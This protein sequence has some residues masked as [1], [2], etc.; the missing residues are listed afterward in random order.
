MASGT[1]KQAFTAIEA[2][3]YWQ[4]FLDVGLL[5]SLAKLEKEDENTLLNILRYFD[6]I[7]VDLR[8]EESLSQA[9]KR[10]SKLKTIRKLL[11]YMPVLIQFDKS[12]STVQLKS[13]L[14]TL[15]EYGIV[16]HGYVHDDFINN[17]PDLAEII[18]LMSTR[19]SPFIPK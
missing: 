3:Q 5:V 4:P 8:Q 13:Q 7:M 12:V 17:R 15:Q 9:T 19:T 10:F 14:K 1:I 18:P 6:Y 11:L 16:D 2:F